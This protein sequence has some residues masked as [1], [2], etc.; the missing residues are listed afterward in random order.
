[1]CCRVVDSATHSQKDGMEGN[2]GS[3]EDGSCFEAF[4]LFLRPALLLTYLLIDLFVGTYRLSSHARLE[5]F[6]IQTKLL[7]TYQ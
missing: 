3:L 2:G 6:V 7:L 1:V 5:A 4:V